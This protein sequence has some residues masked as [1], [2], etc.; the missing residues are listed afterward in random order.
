MSH[1]SDPSLHAVAVTPS[2]VTVLTPTRGL[3]IGTT[4]NVTVRMYGSQ[5]NVTFTTVP[6]GFM[7][8]QVD[9]VRATGTTAS[10]IVALW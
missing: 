10:N 9:Q 1:V 2:D 3:Y 6:V 4:G 7:P 8:L 5:N